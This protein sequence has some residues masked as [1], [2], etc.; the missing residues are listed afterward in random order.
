MLIN[1][2]FNV[3]AILICFVVNFS[4]LK[5]EDFNRLAKVTTKELLQFS[6][7]CCLCYRMN[8]LNLKNRLV[9]F[10]IQNNNDET[11]EVKIQPPRN[12]A[13]IVQSF[14]ITYLCLIE[15]MHHVCILISRLFSLENRLFF[16]KGCTWLT[17]LDVVIIFSHH[18]MFT[19]S[20]FT[21]FMFFLE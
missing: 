18:F 2:I 13:K 9:G 7:N 3:N 16:R 10:C 14:I 8:S 12:C 19:H 15:W 1:I 4:D 17:L 20:C 11:P 21:R 6:K 5:Y